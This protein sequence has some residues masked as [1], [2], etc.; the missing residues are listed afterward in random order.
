MFSNRLVNQLLNISIIITITLIF[1]IQLGAHYSSMSSFLSNT[2]QNQY[3]GQQVTNHPSLTFGDYGG[4]SEG[5]MKFVDNADSVADSVKRHEVE[6]NS[7]L[8]KV[9][10][11]LTIGQPSVDTPPKADIVATV[12]PPPPPP[13]SPP[14]QQQQEKEKH[15]NQVSESYTT[16]LVQN[17]QLTSSKNYNYL[18]SGKKYPIIILTCNRETYLQATID[19][20]LAAHGVRKDD[21]LVI[22]DG[23]H[24]G[25]ENIVLENGLN[26]KQSEGASNLRRGN[27]DGASRIAMHYK[28]ALTLGFSWRPDSPAL[29]IIEDDF[30]FSPDFLEYFE[31]NSPILDIDKTTFIMSA[32]NDNGNIDHVTNKN[33]LKRTNYFPGLGWL[34]TRDLYKN[35]LEK[36][37]PNTHWDHWM[38]DKK[39]H[40]GRD[41]IYPE[42]PRDYHTGVKGTFMDDFHHNHYF[43]NIGYNRDETFSFTGDEF[44][45]VVKD[46][47][48]KDIKDLIVNGKSIKNLNEI[49]GNEQTFVLW[50]NIQVGQPSQPF[51]QISEYFHIWHELERANYNGIHTFRWKGHV[52]A[53]CNLSEVSNDIKVIKGGGD[54]VWKPNEFPKE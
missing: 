45:M 5:I 54:K 11:E 28:Y 6:E 14:P 24:V 35:E 38:R 39:Q 40:K 47:Y 34:L 12:P 15:N 20:L 30:L 13:P 48:D 32:W 27:V 21:I 49:N 37:W 23:K 9:P 42:V 18:Q 3:N 8:V 46:T 43:K 26:L 7:Y 4:R 44:N 10:M 53:I 51:R 2:N 33:I 19:S 1:G 17:P 29:I 16:S 22:Q 36:G 25:V 41:C 31:V 52:F 50:I